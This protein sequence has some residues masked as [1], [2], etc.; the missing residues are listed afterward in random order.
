M[1]V[2]KVKLKALAEGMK[3]WDKMTECWP[4]DENG[5]DWQVGRL[6]EDENRWSL[7]TIDTEQ[8]DQEQDAPKVAQYYAAANPVAVLALLAENERLQLNAKNDAIAYKAAIERQ[9]EIR[10]ERDQLK[11]KLLHQEVE[12]GTLAERMKAA[13]MM[14]VDELLAGAPL[15]AFT[16][17]AG[18]NSLEAFGQWLEMRR[19]EYVTMQA[20]RT[21]DK[22]EE[23]DLYEWVLAHAGVF[24]EVHVNFKAAIACHEKAGASCALDATEAERRLHEVAVHCANVEQDRDQLKAKLAELEAIGAP[25][26]ER[27]GSMPSEATLIAAGFGYPMS[28]EDAVKAYKASLQPRTD[29][30]GNEDCEWCHGCGHDYYGEPCVGCCNPAS[31]PAPAE[32][33]ERAEFEAWAVKNGIATTRTTQ[34]LGFAN[35]QRRNA[36]DYIL[37]E[38]LCSHAAWMARASLDKVA[39]DAIPDDK[40]TGD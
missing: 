4:S 7:L 27:Q 28:K 25:E 37:I 14:T 32:R 33:D 16:R 5:P 17:H 10:A 15:D 22:R 30:P 24:G 21:L 38:S 20:K 9:D 13:G 31:L 19:R 3:G 6:D 36:G 26:A 18:V 11:A 29:H 12:A 1:T 39:H 8:Y 2:D 40:K 23:D 34:A 35:G